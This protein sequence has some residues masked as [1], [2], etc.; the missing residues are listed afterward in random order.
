[1]RAVAN[2]ALEGAPAP[3]RM[4]N[5]SRFGRP[6]DPGYGARRPRCA[7]ADRN[8]P[9]IG[10]PVDS[11]RQ[12]DRPGEASLGMFNGH[13]FYG[14]S[15]AA[16]TGVAAEMSCK[17]RRWRNAPAARG[18]RLEMNVARPRPQR[19]RGS[20]RSRADHGPVGEL[21]RSADGSSSSAEPPDRSAKFVLAPRGATRIV[22]IGSLHGFRRRARPRASHV[23]YNP[24]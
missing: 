12:C 22:R 1:M 16:W 10:L 7:W 8:T 20:S 9:Q 19:L 23:G 13:D 17:H 24:A 2:Q 14:L 21:R 15:T 18:R 6:A 4:P 11:R 5:S 3:R